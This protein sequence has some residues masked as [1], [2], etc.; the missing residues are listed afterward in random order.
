V[1]GND[2][3]GGYGCVCEG[4]T[5]LCR[6]EEGEPS[7]GRDQTILCSETTFQLYS[8]LNH[9]EESVQ[10]QYV[11]ACNSQNIVAFPNTLMQH[12]LKST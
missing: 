12:V 5:A 3:H 4:D 2:P 11:S 7:D 6:G 1:E 10:L 9:P 8:P